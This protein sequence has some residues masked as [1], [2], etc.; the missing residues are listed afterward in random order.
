MRFIFARKERTPNRGRSF[1]YRQE[2]TC[3]RIRNAAGL[4]SLTAN[5]RTLPEFAG[6]PG[7]LVNLRPDQPGRPPDSRARIF[8]DSKPGDQQP[9]GSA[10]RLFFIGA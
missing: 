3:C 2:G 10:G 6:G 9:R 5:R 4:F 8:A 1:L 7:G